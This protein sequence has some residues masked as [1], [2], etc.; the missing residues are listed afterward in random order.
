MV[1]YNVDENIIS[2][3]N[4]KPQA[5]AFSNWVYEQ[6]VAKREFKLGIPIN[7][8]RLKLGTYTHEL[9]DEFYR[10]QWAIRKLN[11]LIV[12]TSDWVVIFSERDASPNNIMYSSKLTIGRRPLGCQPDVILKH[13]TQKKIIIIERKSTTL[14]E[15]RIGPWPNLQTQLWCYSWIDDWSD[16][17]EIT[18]IGQIWTIYGGRN[19]PVLINDHFIWQRS[20]QAHQNYCLKWF[21]LYKMNES[22]SP[23]HS[24]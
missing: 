16:F 21:E 2:P 10:T 11:P 5:S 6:T 20:D 18:L 17:D 1:K 15:S 24:T 7:K 14:P 4:P 19:K 9:I 22:F 3:Q 23:A 13:K 8:D 12:N